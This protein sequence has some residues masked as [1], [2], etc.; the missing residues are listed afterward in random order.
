MEIK[1]KLYLT[2]DLH[3]GH[4]AMIEQKFRPFKSLED[5]N[6]LIIKNLFACDYDFLY[7]LGDVAFSDMK[8]SSFISD[9]EIII[10]GNHDPNSLTNIQSMIIKFKGKNFELVHNPNDASLCADYVIHGHIHKTGGRRFNNNIKQY[11][12]YIWYDDHGN[13]FYNVNVEFHRYK[14][15]LINEILGELEVVKKSLSNKL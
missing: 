3:L 10:K 11:N 15:K 12:E 2:S 8:K 4:K 9:K 5:M 6:N 1:K 13:I 14:P 7:V